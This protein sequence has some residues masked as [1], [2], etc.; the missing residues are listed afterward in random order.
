MQ[1]LFYNKRKF[2][3][4]KTE[5]IVSNVTDFNMYQLY[6]NDTN[7]AI[8]HDTTFLYVLV[9][10][11]Q[12][13]SPSTIRDQQVTLEMTTLR[14]KFLG[15]PNL[16]NMGDFNT[17]ASVENG[18]QSVINPADST[19][20]M[21]DPPYYPDKLLQY[22]GYWDAS[23]QTVASFLTTSTRSSASIP[24]TCGTDG[25]AKGWYD[26]IFISPWLVKGTNYITYIPGS[27]KTI[28]NDGSR[29]GVDINASFPV[30]NIS[31]PAPV[32]DALWQFSNKYPVMLKLLVK[33]NRNGV[34]P[35]DPI[36]RY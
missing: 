12:S 5:T 29:I 35:V 18:Y 19:T 24:N 25:G 2:T 16:I 26:H 20:M 15:F 34:S 14:Y 28:G 23:P 6:Y 3:Y 33:A 13:G 17:S 8:T 1:L 27:Y 30:T 9:N 36:E 31:T 4:L 10:H 21:Y 7:L 32:L 22:P 11:T